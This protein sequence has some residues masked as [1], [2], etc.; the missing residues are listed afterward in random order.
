MDSIKADK[1][2]QDTLK[3]LSLLIENLDKTSEQYYSALEN[4]VKRGN[5]SMTEYYQGRVD[6][7]D[8]A[9]TNA[10][11]ARIKLIDILIPQ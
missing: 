6:F 1:D 4:A 10:V 11:S 2:Y 3:S 9:L 5:A 7:I 8:I